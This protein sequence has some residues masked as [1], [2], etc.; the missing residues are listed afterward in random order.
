MIQD[1]TCPTKNGHFICSS[2]ICKQNLIDADVN[3]V[4]YQEN[5]N[6]CLYVSDASS[7]AH[8]YFTIDVLTYLSIACSQFIRRNLFNQLNVQL[9][10]NQY[11]FVM[12]LK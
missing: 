4:Q 8:K 1:C 6:H 2:A 12:I 11:D 10:V 3:K 5:A 7:L 9:K